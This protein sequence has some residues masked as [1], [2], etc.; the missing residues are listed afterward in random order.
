MF[1]D[2][3]FVCTHTCLH[4]S[5]VEARGQLWVLL[6]NHLPLCFLRQA[7]LLR[8]GAC[9]KFEAPFVLLT[10]AR[11]TNGLHYSMGRWLVV[12][13]TTLSILRTWSC[14]LTLN[15]LPA[16]FKSC[17]FLFKVVSL[18]TLQ[19]VSLNNIVHT[20][21]AWRPLNLAPCPCYSATWLVL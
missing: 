13:L 3:V 15:I 11:I 1:L 5:C 17:H 18:D 7:L 4:V 8:P 9:S 2:C 21:K 16:W 20:Q 14:C 10:R 6:C 19:S 12:L